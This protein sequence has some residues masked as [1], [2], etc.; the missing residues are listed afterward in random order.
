[1]AKPKAIG[2]KKKMTVLAVTEDMHMRVKLFALANGLEMREVTRRA[3]AAAVPE[4]T[5]TTPTTTTTEAEA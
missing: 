1:M 5:I 3:I 2:P 4:L